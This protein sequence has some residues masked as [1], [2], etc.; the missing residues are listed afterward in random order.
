MK[1]NQHNETEE[2]WLKKAA[3]APVEPKKTTAQLNPIP[4]PE[5]VTADNLSLLPLLQGNDQK[6]VRPASEDRYEIGREFARGGLGRVL[7]AKDKK[8]ERT[9][10]LKELLS[11]NH[12]MKE[13]F[14]REVL[15]TA[16]LEHP[17]II[18]IH[19]IGVQPNGDLYYAMK[20]VDGRSL[21]KVIVEKKTLAERLSLL[22]QVIDACSAI[23]YA[24]DKN[25]IHRDLKPHNIML[26][27]FGETIVIDWGLAKDLSQGADPHSEPPQAL[28]EA[29]RENEKEMLTKFGSIIGTPAYMP[30]EQARG[31]PVDKR[32]DVYSLGAILYHLLV[33]APP[34]QGRRTHD[35]LSQVISENPPSVESLQPKAPKEILS[36][37]GRAM[38]RDAQERY[39]SAAELLNELILF[40]QGKIVGAHV[41]S[42]WE[43]LGRWFKKY[44]IF[45]AAFIFGATASLMQSP[46]IKK[47]RD[48]LEHIQSAHQQ[49]KEDR[50][51]LQ[52]Q[53]EGLIL[54]EAREAL[55][56]DPF[57]SLDL[58]KQLP[59]TS[60]Q[61]SA[62]NEIAIEASKK[63]APQIIFSDGDSI[64]L[65][66]TLPSPNGDFNA[67]ISEKEG[68]SLWSFET[69][70]IKYSAKRS[71]QP[72]PWPSRKMVSTWRSIQLPTE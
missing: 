69:G 66:Y 72:L 8:L 43:R 16:K 3:A 9:V 57:K 30:P 33:G 59:V 53:L 40:Q 55:D 42:V 48:A 70:P 15:L 13:R 25:V 27:A 24:H 41:Y 18:P 38:S 60:S 5:S 37:V 34:Y 28:S 44:R 2:S 62:A 71:P 12:K 1:S 21:D 32:A 39:P 45:V 49:V 63:G 51:K 22:P 58:L 14:L 31:E 50:D 6:R 68:L 23:A 67:V 19:D 54:S 47:L 46:T 65:N 17:G 26:G 56:Q 20:L 61:W 35:T 11:D 4:R 10:V 52:K 29:Y 64:N 7:F 36:I